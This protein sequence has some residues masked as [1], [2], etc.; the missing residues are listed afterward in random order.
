M[1]GGWRGVGAWTLALLV[2][3]LLGLGLWMRPGETSSDVVLRLEGSTDGLLHPEAAHEQVV[4]VCAACH[5][6]PEPE[7]F[8]RHDW[9]NEVVRG[10]DFYAKSGLALDAPPAV[11][12]VRYYKNRAPSALAQGVRAPRPEPEWDWFEESRHRWEGFEPP[13]FSHVR[14]V[15]SGNGARLDVL[16][17]EMNGRVMLWNPSDPTSPPRVLASG[18]ESPAHAEMADLDGDGLAD[19]LV[20]TLGSRAPTDVPVGSVVWLRGLGGGEYAKHGIADGLGRVSDVRA[21]DFDG[22]GDLDVVVA[23]FGFWKTGGIFLLENERDSTGQTRFQARILDP[24]AGCV[25]LEVADLNGDGRP[26]F[27]AAISQEHEVV[28]AFLSE[29]GVQFRTERIFAAGHP[30]LGMSGAQ[31]VDMDGDGDLDVLLSHGDVLDKKFLPPYQGVQWLENRGAFPFDPHWL[32]AM[33]GTMR[34]LAA[35]LDGDGDMDILGTVFLP[36][37]HFLRIRPDEMESIYVLEQVAPRQFVRHVVARGGQDLAACDAGDFD[38]DGHPDLVTATC[39]FIDPVDDPAPRGRDW[40]ILGRGLACG[41]ARLP[42][43]RNRDT[44]APVR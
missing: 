26:D 33:P 13:A 18:L 38:A 21:A 11:E 9:A 35:D 29:G 7:L 37:P 39:L 34:A 36:G 22:D 42:L 24:R 14:F 15:P 23:A 32:E 25:S 41:A 17:C 44:I 10:F 27:V 16:A 43:E 4:A 20:G 3:V 6:F 19:I 31:V 40:F 5:G 2:I 1:T 8:A 12:V 30:A 28:E